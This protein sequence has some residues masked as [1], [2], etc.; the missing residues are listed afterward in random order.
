MCDAISF[1]QDVM[2]LTYLVRGGDGKEYG[3][4]TQDQVAGWIR[5]GRLAGHQQIKR[6]DMQDWAAASAF[7]EF[8]SLF[9]PPAMPIAIPPGAAPATSSH[10]GASPGA[11]TRMRSGASWFYWI[12]GISLI[13]S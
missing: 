6:S 8:Q 5:D 11:I 13:N 10:A 3:P 7:I 12:A 9:Q 4:A 2:E 1:G